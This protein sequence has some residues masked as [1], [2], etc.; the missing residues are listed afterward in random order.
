MQSP[1]TLPRTTVGK[2]LVM[3]L[4]GL[5]LFGFVVAHM[6]GNLKIFLGPDKFNDYAHFL[7]E[8]G[9]HAFGESG[10]LW[11]A[12]VG[13]LAAL[14]AHVVSAV[15]VAAQSGRARPVA[16]KRGNDL[17]FS[18]ASR[19]MRWG[20]V[21]LLAFVIYHLLHLTFGK[22]HPDFDVA[23]AYANVVSG[24]QVWW[25]VGFYILAMVSLGLHLYHGLWSATQTL[26]LR[27]PVVTRFRRPVALAIAIGIT[28]GYLSVPLAVLA[29]WVD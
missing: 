22:V 12:R 3:A 13:L 14:G 29:G 1:A 5:A 19:T 26:A 4:S 28:F 11:I 17:S 23:S 27:W 18:Y 21:I 20:G 7:R 6:A 15:Q 2:K 24:F 10:L 9:S 25:V 16:Y 8:V